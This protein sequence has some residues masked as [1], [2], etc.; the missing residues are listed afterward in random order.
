MAVTDPMVRRSGTP[1]F[2]GREPWGSWQGTMGYFRTKNQMLTINILQKQQHT[3]LTF[4]TMTK[5]QDWIHEGKPHSSTPRREGMEWVCW[6]LY[7]QV[8][9]H[10]FTLALERGARWIGIRILALIWATFY[11]YGIIFVYL[12]TEL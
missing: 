6:V 7:P 1:R 9:Q 10:N 5:W 2:A 11:I 4:S 8:L 12:H 3:I